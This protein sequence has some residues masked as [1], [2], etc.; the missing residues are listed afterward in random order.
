MTTPDD[1]YRA[2]DLE[3]ARIRSLAGHDLSDLPVAER[4]LARTLNRIE[5]GEPDPYAGRDPRGGRARPRVLLAAA[6]ALI[7]IVVSIPL[8]W[9]STPAIA[10]PPSLVYSLASPA[11]AATAP[12]AAEVLRALADS[13]QRTPIPGGGTV[14]YIASQ[15]WTTP[16]DADAR[17]ATILPVF[18][19][20]WLQADGSFVLEQRTGAELRPDG[21]IDPNPPLR[22]PEFSRDSSPAGS[23]PDTVTLLPRDPS[24]LR[25]ELLTDMPPECTT[26]ADI[27]AACLLEQ[28][29]WLSTTYL[30]PGDLAATLWEVLATEPAIHTLGRTRDRAGRDVVALAAPPRNSD[31]GTTVLVLLADLTTGRMVGTET[32]TLATDYLEIEGPTVTAFTTITDARLVTTPG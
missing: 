15:N 21:T 32:M 10:A 1:R 31:Y 27:T 25:A 18:Q 12:S 5:A 17:R 3:V 14:Q 9:T 20:W 7:A 23:M 6:A 26:H 24:T 28:T 11:D 19:E 4:V 8:W 30:I 22:A 16:L 29:A 2:A 13:A